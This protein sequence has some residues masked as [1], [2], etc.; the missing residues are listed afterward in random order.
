MENNMKM[1]KISSSESPPYEAMTIVVAVC[2]CSHLYCLAHVMKM[3]L[4]NKGLPYEP[5]C[6]LRH[7]LS[8]F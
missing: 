8:Y 5:F 1:T 7:T 6:L 3:M 2:I 4:Q